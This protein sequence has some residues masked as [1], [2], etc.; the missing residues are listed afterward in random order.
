[1]KKHILV[2]I[3][4]ILGLNISHAA[5][6]FTSIASGNYGVAGT[7]SFVGTSSTGIPTRYDDV[8]ITNGKTVTMNVSSNAKTLTIN[9]GGVL[10]L[11]NLSILIWGNF[12]N[13]GWY[14]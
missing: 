8:I 13:N 6:V 11:N 4:S 14:K 7:W 1:M 12:T 5:A 9:V 2:V 3:I 10:S